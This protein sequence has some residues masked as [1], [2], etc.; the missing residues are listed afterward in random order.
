MIKAIRAK[1]NKS[2]KKRTNNKQKSKTYKKHQKGGAIYSFNLNQKV[3]G[4]PENMSLNGTQDGDC[5]T[6][7]ELDLGFT[8][9]GLT[10]GGSYKKKHKKNLSK[11]RKSKK[12]KRSKSSK[13][14]KSIMRKHKK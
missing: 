7:G 9:Y 11:S 2:T 12:S 10:K 14:R 1:V 13:S 6:S 5:P 4:L 8:N 3:G